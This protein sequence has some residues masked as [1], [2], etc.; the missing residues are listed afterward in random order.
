[1]A[2]DE[3]SELAGFDRRSGVSALVDADDGNIGDAW[4]R[5]NAGETFQY[6]ADD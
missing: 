3:A 1:M 4:C 2:E 5:V 6:I